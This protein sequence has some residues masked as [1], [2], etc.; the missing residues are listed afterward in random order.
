MELEE[1]MHAVKRA[2]G[3]PETI[4]RIRYW[5]RVMVRLF[6]KDAMTYDPDPLSKRFKAVEALLARRISAFAVIRM[7]REFG[8]EPRICRP[9]GLAVSD[10]PEDLEDDDLVDIFD[11]IFE[12][13][14]SFVGDISLFS[15]VGSDICK[16]EFPLL[17][18]TDR[19]YA[20][21]D[22]MALLEE[23]IEETLRNEVFP[24]IMDC[25]ED[26]EAQEILDDAKEVLLYEMGISLIV[27]KMPVYKQLAET[28]I[29]KEEEQLRET[30]LRHH[31]SVL[32]EPWYGYSFGSEVPVTVTSTNYDDPENGNY[33]TRDITRLD[34][35]E[36]G[37]RFLAL[38]LLEYAKRNFVH[39]EQ[40][41]AEVRVHERR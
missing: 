31:H 11:D 25:V 26:E 5:T 22:D 29:P 35:V 19:F 15:A 17:E 27:E 1:V 8:L 30:I 3:K 10:L 39:S 4:S 13:M 2:A 28:V 40:D 7:F 32:A 41:T 20:G 16:I 24:L 37:F 18:E 21:T 23:H 38:L 36:L 9:D 12:E 33:F 14:H 6:H 34:V